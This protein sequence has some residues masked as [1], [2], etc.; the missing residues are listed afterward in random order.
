M[1]WVA[2]SN[3]TL[4]N[5]VASVDDP[6]AFLRIRALGSTETTALLHH[7]AAELTRGQLEMWE[8]AQLVLGCFLFSFLLFGTAEGKVPLALALLL[9]IAVA[10]QRFALTPQLES[11]GRLTDFMNSSAA[12]GYRARLVVMQGAYAGVELAKWVSGIALGII[13]IARRNVRSGDSWQ[14]FNVIDKANHRHVDR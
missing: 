12:A 10:V 5:R 4:A 1:A 11:L 14:Q 8:I 6:A 2:T 7:Q 9:L 3:T 13:L